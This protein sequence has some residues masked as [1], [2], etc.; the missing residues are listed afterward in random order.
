MHIEISTIIKKICCNNKNAKNKNVREKN[1]RD[2]M[3]K[4]DEWT[5]ERKRKKIAW[6]AE[7]GTLARAARDFLEETLLTFGL[8]AASCSSCRKPKIAKIAEVRRLRIST[9]KAP[10]PASLR[11]ELIIT[12]RKIQAPTNWR[13]FRKSISFCI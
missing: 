9:G 13:G 8:F 5:N 1:E 6:E 4:M 7:V 2:R 3:I 12:K 10:S 11:C